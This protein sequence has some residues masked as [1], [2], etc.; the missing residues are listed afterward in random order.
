VDIIGAVLIQNLLAQ[1]GPYCTRQKLLLRP[2]AG[3]SYSEDESNSFSPKSQYLSLFTKIH[4][5][6]HQ[7]R[8]LL[9]D[10]SDN[11]ICSCLSKAML[12]NF[13]STDEIRRVLNVKEGTAALTNTKLC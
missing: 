6:T 5:A 10:Y 4:D 8:Y 1:D 13:N 2:Q 12:K 11:L 7:N 3:R 9:S